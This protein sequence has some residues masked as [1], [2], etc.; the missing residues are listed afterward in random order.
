MRCACGGSLKYEPVDWS[1]ADGV[2]AH[3]TGRNAGHAFA[4]GD[5]LVGLGHL[6]ARAASMAFK[7]MRR[8]LPWKCT[9]CGQRSSG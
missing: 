7:A 2:A 9:S 6:A 1:H 4:T 3:M 5:P 8:A